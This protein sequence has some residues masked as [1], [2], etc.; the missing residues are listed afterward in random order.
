M[1]MTIPAAIHLQW[2][3]NGIAV[4]AMEDRE[5]KNTF[6]GAFTRGLSLAFEEIAATERARAVVI[7]GYDNYF[8]C[9]GTRDQLIGLSESRL[10]YTD[11][12]D[13]EMLLRCEV[14]VIAA[15]QGH[16]IGGGF[17]FGAYADI[18]ILAE[19]G[20]YNTNFMQYGF[21][22]GMGATFI[23]PHKLGPVLGWEMLLTGR[24]YRGAE[25]RER[26]AQLQISRKSQVINCALE[27]AEH[28]A[29]KP[30]PS[31]RQLKGRFIETIARD[32][33]AAIES[34]LKMQS[35]TCPL[36]EVRQRIDLLYPV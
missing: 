14:P 5:A 36:A 24:N 10:D 8:C 1:T 12:M 34:E 23:I 7:H 11:I 4:V 26:G 15:M 28:L 30:I 18:V 21:T 9:G 17:V 31:L 20:I 27:Q 3:D 6:S 13:F 29:Q 35:L 2:R 33:T 25:L 19:E 16:A 22:P 32:L